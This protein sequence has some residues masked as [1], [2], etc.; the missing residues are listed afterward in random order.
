MKRRV[1]SINDIDM[2]YGRIVSCLVNEYNSNSLTKNTERGR[3]LIERRKKIDRIAHE[4][5][6]NIA[7]HYV[8]LNGIHDEFEGRDKKVLRGKYMNLSKKNN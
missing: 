4:Y 6:K 3:I 7:G 8:V 5:A 2:Q 1:K